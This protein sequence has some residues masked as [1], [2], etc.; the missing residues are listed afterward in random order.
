MR[1]PI[2]YP[3]DV[4]MTRG[5][6]WV[7]RAIR[8]M[9]Q[10]KGEPPSIVN[11]VGIIVEGGTIQRALVVEAVSRVRRVAIGEA[12]R[13]GKT[14]VAIARPLNLTG[15]Q[16]AQLCSRAE[17]Y[18]GRKYGYGKI[19]AHLGDALLG[20]R[21]YFRRL[22][23]ADER[24]MCSWLVAQCFAEI[25]LHFGVDARLA[26]PDDILD[27]VADNPDKYRLIRHLALV[28]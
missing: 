3:G 25:G 15:K 22:V 1:E 28:P 10:R 5:T 19:V 7:S 11:H 20:G 21:V 4:M 8:R 12:Y 18:V 23:K 27:F 13:D 6:K 9:T 14:R 2:L 17:G 16:I 26:N 24:P